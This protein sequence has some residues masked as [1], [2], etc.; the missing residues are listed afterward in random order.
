MATNSIFGVKNRTFWRAAIAGRSVNHGLPQAVAGQYS[1]LIGH[2]AAVDRPR[3]FAVGAGPALPVSVA[4]TAK[5][6]HG[7]PSRFSNNKRRP[8][9]NSAR[10]AMQ[11]GATITLSRRSFHKNSWPPKWMRWV[12][13]RRATVGRKA[14]KHAETVPD[15]LCRKHSRPVSGRRPSAS[16]TR[17]TWGSFLPAQR[18]GLCFLRSH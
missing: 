16:E 13:D 8:S 6:E 2:L 5:R 11:R 10:D 14:W 15:R 3:P 9:M 7:K 12:S 4:R 17:E 1:A 18:A